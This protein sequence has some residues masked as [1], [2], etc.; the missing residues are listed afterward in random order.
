VVL[1]EER[2]FL[3]T[4][5]QPAKKFRMI[6]K[7]FNIQNPKFIFN[8]LFTL[9]PLSF[10]FH[11][12]PSAPSMPLLK[13]LPG[14]LGIFAIAYLAACGL[15]LLGQRRLIF[16]PTP[17]LIT[18]P[19]EFA[20]AYE[21]VWITV[22]SATKAQLH[23]WWLPGD[24]QGLPLTVLYL[25]GNAG[26]ISSHMDR[27]VRLRSLGLSVLI[28]DYRGYGLSSGPFP[29][30][31]RM[32]ADAVAALNF[33]QEQKSIPTSQIL[34]YGHSIGGAVGIDLASQ[35]PQAAGLIVES[36]FTSM[37]DMAAITGY[38]RWFPV[39]LLLTQRFDSLQ[40]V[41]ELDLP[42]FYLHGLE[43]EAIPPT[44]SQQLY[45]VTN[46][47]KD[48]WLVPNAD[49]NNI[50]AETSLEFERRITQFIHEYIRVTQHP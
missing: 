36:S 44:M 48:L 31:T 24:P 39:R 6:E 22:D 10:T 46:A 1:G 41:P 50:P 49:H 27:V 11:P 33:L 32:Y 23:G 42:T 26:N 38:N 18:T 13:L 34:I 35:F 3:A 14:A 5:G 20:L 9:N 17:M 16:L 12:L 45:A 4:E 15:L 37:G 25:H 40:K 47:P 19:Q 2:V 43:D 29:T 7:H 28:I 30:E 8:T 21:D